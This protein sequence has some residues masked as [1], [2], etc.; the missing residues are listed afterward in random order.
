[1]NAA[2]ASAIASRLAGFRTGLRALGYVEGENV[3]VEYRYADG[4]LERLSTLAAELVQLK[5]DLIVTGGPQATSAARDATTTVPIVMAT[6]SDPIGAG[7]VESLARPGGNIT[8]LSTLAPAMGGKSLELLKEALPSLSRLALLE[9]SSSQ[10]LSEVRRDTERTARALGVQLSYFDLPEPTSLQ[11]AFAALVAGGAEAVLVLPSPVLVTQRAT[12]VGLAASH[13][14]PA[15]Y[16][17]PEYSQAGGLLYYGA[18]RLEMHR[19]AAGYV[20][21]ILRGARPS[22]LPVEQPATFDLVVNL[23]TA[24]ALGR[25]VPRSLLEQATEIIQ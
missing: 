25:S 23:A 13:R 1:L 22:E 15:M 9:T 21:K 2:P 19:R 5:P 10:S 8:G 20:D 12:V 18:S 11:P 4:Q 7:F 6:E 3:V 16:N 17:E 24:R 14:L